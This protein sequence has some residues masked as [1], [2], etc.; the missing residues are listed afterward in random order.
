MLNIPEKKTISEEEFRTL[1]PKTFTI[2]TALACNLKCPECAIGGD[3]IGRTKNLMK[4][5]RFK[6][7]ADKARPFCEYMYLHLW[8]EPTLNKRIFDMISYASEFTRTNISTNALLLD[9]EKA[10]KLITSGVTDLIVSIDGFSQEIYEQYRVGGDVQEAFR[11]LTWLK[12]FKDK[13]GSSVHIAPQ[14]IVFKHNQHEMEEFESLC[15]MLDLNPSFKA[16]YIRTTD[17]TFAL[18][19][20]KRFHR[21]HYETITALRSAMMDCANPREVFTMLSDG[22][23]VVCCHDFD[24]ATYFGNIFEQDVLEIW[25]SPKY[26]NYRW[27]I[28][29][30]NAPKFCLQSC[31]SYIPGKDC[32]K[33]IQS[34]FGTETVSE[35]PEEPIVTIGQ[36]SKPSSCTSCSPVNKTTEEK[37]LRRDAKRAPHRIDL[38]TTDPNKALEMARSF[39]ASDEYVEGIDLYEQISEAFPDHSIK[40]LSELYDQ[41]HKLPKG[42]NRYHLYVARDYDFNIRPGEKVLDIGSGHDP[43]PYATHLADFAPDDNDYGRAGVALKRPDG[44]PFTECNVENTP[45]KDHEFDFVYCSHVLEHTESPE[46]A[47]QELQRIARRGYIETPSPGKD[48]W[49]NSAR[50]S[51]HNWSVQ[52][53]GNKIQFQEYTEEQKDAIG[54]DIVMDMHCSP[55][56]EREKALSALI[57][58]KSRVINTHMY[59]EDSFEY[60]VVRRN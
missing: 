20:D 10:E 2:E 38:K 56:T 28:V 23:V 8:G 4:F 21:P 44:I 37:P 47:C 29:S 15:D 11:S 39:I 48:F 51:N 13:H 34:Q 42:K 5:D 36:H 53:F 27:D 3:M 16:P 40:V 22:S 46:K 60:E 41:Y 12:E 55:Q 26:Y 6:E 49:M 30:G 24:S 59:W 9:R 1:T 14:F 32:E 43:F 57:W 45:F 35:Q 25:N 33:Q 50:I 54:C 19:D 58:L 31:M 17:S 18:P 7:I 52:V